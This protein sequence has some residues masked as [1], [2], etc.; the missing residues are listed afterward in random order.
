M[1]RDGDGYLSIPS[2]DGPSDIRS[3]TSHRSGGSPSRHTSTSHPGSRRPSNA[4]SSSGPQGYPAPFGFD[5][6]REKKKFGE[7]FNK[8]VDLPPEAYVEV[9]LSQYIRRL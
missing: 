2:F 7:D 3:D 4:G 8:N 6:A 1:S 5:P 9:S